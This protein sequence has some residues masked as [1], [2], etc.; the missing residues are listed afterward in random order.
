MISAQENCP[1]YSGHLVQEVILASL[2]HPHPSFHFP[3]FLVVDT[4]GF[5]YLFQVR[6]KYTG[7]RI[8]LPQAQWRGCLWP[9]CSWLFQE[10]PLSTSSR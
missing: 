3:C 10:P 4:A 7:H 8:D 5:L 6:V 9:S 2:H 1:D